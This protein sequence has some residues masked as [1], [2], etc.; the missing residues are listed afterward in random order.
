MS[1]IATQLDHTFQLIQSGNNQQALINAKQLVSLNP[2]N[3]DV[4]H[5]TALAYKAN[6]DFANAKNFFEMS[7]KVNQAQPQVLNNLANLYKDN[8]QNQQAE[9]YYLKAIKLQ[10]N[11]FDAFKNAAINYLELKQYD[12]ALDYLVNSNKLKPNDYSVITL[13]GDCYRAQN[14]FTNA[15]AY[16]QQA[17][18]LNPS[19]VNALHN[20]GLCFHLNGEHQAALQ[21]YEQAYNLG[22]D[23]TKVLLSYA[24][25][26][27]DSGQYEQA[28]SLLKQGLKI[29]PNEI[30]LHFRLNE[31]LW[32][33]NRK[34]QFCT[35]YLEVLGPTSD[36]EQLRRAHIEQLISAGLIEQAEF[37][38]ANGLKKY[39]NSASLTAL[40]GSVM[41]D[42][43]EY[44]AAIDAFNYSLSQVFDKNAAQQLVK[45]LIIQKDYA[46]AQVILDALIN[47]EPDCQLTWGLQSIIWRFTD[48]EKYQWLNNYQSF[49]YAEKL[50]VPAAYSNRE[51]FLQ[52]LRTV[53]EKQHKTVSAPLQQTLKNGTQTAA[54]LL[55][56]PIKEIQELR[57]EVLKIAS[58]YIATFPDD[59]HHP[60]LRRKSDNIDISGSWSVKLRPNGFHVNH[61]HPAGWISSSCYIT[62]PESMNQGDEKNGAIKF[63]ETP[64]ALGDREV[65]EKLIHPEAGMVVL[66]PSYM[67]HGTFPFN[68]SDDEYRMTAPFDVM[69]VI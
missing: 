23:N 66:F 22:S 67:W 1:N 26:L 58:N 62:I 60:L 4:L 34:D 37:Q 29:K 36:D 7:L 59:K 8:N 51:E 61:V 44:D 39:P 25:L 19:A 27:N 48:K 2:N 40:Y 55:H 63:G 18:S 33:L 9:N 6:D 47:V 45:A 28:I 54:R 20:L 5:I 50:G 46:K 16:Y 15:I 35:S 68:G 17:I 3:P 65:V 31:F 53:L 64:L 14:K 30:M 57:T 24:S 21:Y 11:Y 69:P 42:K 12:N 32:E 13:F 38:L 52:A 43:L 10:S 49:V 41:A 56:L